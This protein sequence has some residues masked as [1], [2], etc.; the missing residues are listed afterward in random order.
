MSQHLRP[1]MN[2]IPLSRV[3]VQGGFWGQWQETI[4]TATIPASFQRLKETGRID[5]FRLKWKRG[6]PNPPHMFW[7]SDVAKWVETAAYALVT[8]PDAELKHL[9]NE[10]AELIASAQQRD[11]YLNTHFT[12][13]EPD[14]RWVNLRDNHELY[15]A[16]HL[17]EAAVAHYLAT[18]NDTLLQAVQKYADYIDAVFGLEEGKMRGYCGHEE[19]ELALVKLYRLTAEPRYLQLAKYFIDQRGQIPDYFEEEARRRGEP[20]KGYG[21]FVAMVRGDACR[22]APPGN[23]MYYQNHLP[24]REQDEV[25]GHAVRALYLLSGMVDVA[26]ETGDAALFATCQRLWEDVCERKMYVTGSLGPS[27]VNEGFTC[28]YDLPNET[29]YAETCAAVALVFFDHRMLQLDLDGRYA[30][31][32]ERALF[33]GALS[34][35]SLDGTKFFYENPLAVLHPAAPRLRQEW[36]GCACCPNNI[37]R[38]LASLGIYMYSE[39]ADGVAV[40]LYGASEVLLTIGGQSVTLSQETNYPWDGKVVI[41][42]AP[43]HPAEFSMRLR[44]PG[45]CPIGTVA[46]NGTNLPTKIKKGYITITRKWQ[47]GDAVE[48]NFE[49]AVRRVYAHPQVKADIG[50]VAIARGPL[51]YCLEEVDNGRDLDAIYLPRNAAFQYK[52]EN[53]L[54]GGVG[55]VTSEALKQDAQDASN[56]LYRD[57]A[58]TFQAATI[59][60]VPYFA[61]ANRQ[62]GEMLVWLREIMTTDK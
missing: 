47:E 11:G 9:V 2:P 18:D 38:L 4:R 46:E 3:K 50:R 34:G 36:F 19:I 35:I 30:D 28:A 12:V 55:I 1:V 40:H 49:M 48:V 41:N 27:R 56:V 53:D 26:Q 15:C 6:M 43:G 10:T 23:P 16:G 22:P 20:P 62:P 39:A 5:A 7:D 42:V 33:N 57:N 29:A 31:E 8:H 21:D 58:G 51:I 59:R 54:L 13:V 60:A 45:W 14:K 44:W 17:M 37:S 52:F 32:A 24:V 25:V 61:W